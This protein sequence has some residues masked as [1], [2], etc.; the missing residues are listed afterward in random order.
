MLFSRVWRGAKERIFWALLRSAL[1]ALRW[2]RQNVVGASRPARHRISGYQRTAFD[3]C[4]SK[5]LA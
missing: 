3:G 2:R 4:A 1:A 5:L